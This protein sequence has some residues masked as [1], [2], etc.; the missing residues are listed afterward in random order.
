MA[1]ILFLLA[2]A[3]RAKSGYLSQITLSVSLSSIFLGSAHQSILGVP[4]APQLLPENEVYVTRLAMGI[5]PSLASLHGKLF[6]KATLTNTTSMWTTCQNLPRPKA[7]R[8]DNFL[9]IVVL[10]YCT[11]ATISSPDC[12]AVVIFLRARP[13]D[14]RIPK[15]FCMSALM[16]L[17]AIQNPYRHALD[18]TAVLSHPSR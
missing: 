10:H 15:I 14:V 6:L 9:K 4:F 7:T 1:C 11:T 3:R 18:I 13:Q 12:C 2:C 16:H 5:R 8:T 17:S